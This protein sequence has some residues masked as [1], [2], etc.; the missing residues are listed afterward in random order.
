MPGHW[1]DFEWLPFSQ[2]FIPNTIHLGHIDKISWYKTWTPEDLRGV[3]PLHNSISLNPSTRK[4][5][6]VN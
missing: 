2:A 3:T 1:S 5:G 4:V 6:G